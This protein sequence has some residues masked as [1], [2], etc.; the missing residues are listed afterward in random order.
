VLGAA[1][2]LYPGKRIMK[3][4]LANFQMLGRLQR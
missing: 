2:G 1:Q 4:S 3:D